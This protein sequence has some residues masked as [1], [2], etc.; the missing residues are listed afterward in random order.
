MVLPLSDPVLSTLEEARQ[1]YIA[2]TSEAGP[3]VTPDLYAWSGDAL[4]FAMAVTTLKARVLADDP[5][6]CVVVSA[7]GRSILL[8]GS[9][10]LYDPRRVLAL[11]R[12]AGDLPRTARALTRFTVRNA[13]D[14]LAFMRDVASGRLGLRPPPLRVLA[15]LDPDHAAVIQADAI[16][17]GYGGWAD[18]ASTADLRQDPGGQPAVVALPGPVAVP[19]RWF[20]HEHYVRVPA[21]VRELADLPRTFPLGVVVDEYGAPGPAAKTGAL[22]RGRGRWA[23]DP[24]TI[25]VEPERVVT[26]DGV[27]TASESWAAA[28]G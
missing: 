28:T 18:A 13:P 14:L 22:L 11:G 3:H 2:I 10:T 20:E 26:W 9:A 23:D 12:K 5:R 8:G 16:V 15:R 21:G 6:A 25:D 19:C 17:E 27:E 24:N 1:A 7:P 4:W